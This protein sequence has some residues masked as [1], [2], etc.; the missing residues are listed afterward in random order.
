[1]RNY[2]QQ[3]WLKYRSFLSIPT[4]ALH[5]TDRLDAYTSMSMDASC[6]DV[7]CGRKTVLQHVI[8]VKRNMQKISFRGGYLAQD[9]HCAEHMQ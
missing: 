6:M 9:N 2:E 3:D 7:L 4:M 5:H 1:M 8:H